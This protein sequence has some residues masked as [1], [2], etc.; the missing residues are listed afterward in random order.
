[1]GWINGPKRAATYLS[2]WMHLL[3]SRKILGITQ[4]NAEGHLGREQRYG[5]CCLHRRDN[6]LLLH[7]DEEKLRE[8][9]MTVLVLT[10]IFDELSQVSAWTNSSSG[11][12]WISKQLCGKGNESAEKL[13]KIVVEA[14]AMLEWHTVSA[15]SLAQLTARMTAAIL[16][17]HPAHL[18]YR[19]L[20]HLKHLALR[21]NEFYNVQLTLSLGAR[22]NLHWWV[23]N[24]ATWNG[25]VVWE[26]STDVVTETD[27]S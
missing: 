14:K 27:A 9:S 24:L 25:R 2:P 20:Q 22:K 5:L 23:E 15:Q 21:R 26:V 11:I 13:K 12:P 3:L 6:L 4:G 8:F 16:A 1:M 10:G 19:G 17:V 7:Q 18:H